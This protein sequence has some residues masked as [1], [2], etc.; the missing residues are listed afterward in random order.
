MVGRVKVAEW[1]GGCWLQNDS[2]ACFNLY[3]PPG[4]VIP[5]LSVT[6]VC[7]TR[8]VG[9]ASRAWQHCREVVQRNCDDDQVTLVLSGVFGIEGVREIL[10]VRTGMGADPSG[11]SPTLPIQEYVLFLPSPP[12]P[13]PTFIP[14]SLFLSLPPSV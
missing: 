3:T 9:E 8:W 11:K 12:L 4:F 10:Q 6:R 1:V 7:P 14:F 13:S 2:L 5:L